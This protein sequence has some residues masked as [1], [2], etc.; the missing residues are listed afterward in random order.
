MY[1]IRNH[2]VIEVIEEG[3]DCILIPVNVGKLKGI[4]ARKKDGLKIG[5]TIEY[6]RFEEGAGLFADYGLF[7]KK[8]RTETLD[9]LTT[10]SAK[11]D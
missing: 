11:A 10:C 9:S 1:A 6:E 7:V 8:K 2:Q 3:E 5:D 4:L